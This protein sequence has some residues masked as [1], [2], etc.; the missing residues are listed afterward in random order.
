MDTIK[1]NIIGILAAAFLASMVLAWNERIPDPWGLLLVL[2]TF[3]A[4]GISLAALA[5]KKANKQG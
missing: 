5:I 2:V 3:L 4:L 1:R